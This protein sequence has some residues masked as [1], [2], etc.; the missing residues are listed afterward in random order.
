MQHVC[1]G[2]RYEREGNRIARPVIKQADPRVSWVAES[3]TARVAR[4]EMNPGVV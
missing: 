4:L 3:G 1:I 2:Y